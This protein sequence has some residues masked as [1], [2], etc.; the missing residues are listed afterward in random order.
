M[1]RDGREPNTSAFYESLP[2]DE[3]DAARDAAQA[4]RTLMQNMIKDYLAIGAEL[5]EVK[6][7][8]GHGHFGA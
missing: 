4:I 5:I 8:L 6:E 7:K 2:P 3:R 1:D